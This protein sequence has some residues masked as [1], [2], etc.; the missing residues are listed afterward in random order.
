MRKL[1]LEIVFYST[2]ISI[3]TY[4]LVFTIIEVYIFSLIIGNIATAISI[5]SIIIMFLLIERISKKDI[6]KLFKKLKDE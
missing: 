5:V 2:V 6:D 4:L 3:L 1:K